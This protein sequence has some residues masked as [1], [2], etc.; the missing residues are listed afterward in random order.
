MTNINGSWFLLTIAHYFCYWPIAAY[1]FEML[2]FW[3][4]KQQLNFEII[5]EL[6]MS[7]I[8]DS[9]YIQSV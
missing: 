5:M 3:I 8:T 9:T 1:A 4:W 2:N 7:D 6:E